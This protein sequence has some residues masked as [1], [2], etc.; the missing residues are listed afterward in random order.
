MIK[1]LQWSTKHIWKEL[2][3]FVLLWMGHGK[4]PI[5]K[6]QQIL[7]LALVLRKGIST[8]PAV[9]CRGLLE[10]PA[11]AA[12]ISC[13]LTCFFWPI[14][15]ALSIACKS[16]WGFQ[17][18][19]NRST[20][21]AVYKLIPRPPALWSWMKLHAKKRKKS[22]RRCH[23]NYLVDSMK[24]NFSLPSALY[25]WICRS[26]SSCGVWPSILQYFH[27]LYQQ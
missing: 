15:W 10:I 16:I 20:T 1:S 18:L 24:M 2:L 9:H 5:A 21:S 25:S 13:S 11:I 8:T 17:S 4:H 26:L 12:F 7:K 23:E 22:E 27:P 14:L 3:L 19:S 6:H